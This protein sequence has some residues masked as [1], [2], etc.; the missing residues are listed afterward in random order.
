MTTTT[1][2]A[3][4]R[5]PAPARRAWVRQVMGMPISVHVRGA[6]TAP[7]PRQID[8]AVA[9]VFDELRVHEARFST[10]RPDSEISRLQRGDLSLRDASADVRAV[11]RL[12]RAAAQRTDG[13]F[14]AWYAS[15]GR[16][17]V[18]D[19]TGLVKSW[20][21]SRAARHLDPVA[22]S[23]F[24][25]AVSAGGDVLIRAGA[26]SSAAD[27]EGEPWRI[28]IED[29]FDRRRVLSTVQVSDGGVATSGLA[30]R[31]AHIV[32]PSTGSAARE[33]ASATVIGPSLV[34]ADVFA[35][36]LVA[37]GRDAV[38]WSGTMHGTSGL[39]VLAD[40]GVHRWANPA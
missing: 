28:G 5:T 30:A 1:A 34:W 25:W 10:Y 35:T 37:L 32:D 24:S 13:F 6:R 21:L 38:R 23:G 36:A 20:A 39:L 9:A 8:A 15:P 33:V 4:P 2:P 27:Q 19:P 12:C 29:P 26:P 11:E 31:G 40:G 22:A 16:P 7:E 18:F 17:A 14:D 3:T